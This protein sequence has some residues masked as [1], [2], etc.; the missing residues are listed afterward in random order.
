M[1]IIHRKHVSAVKLSSSSIINIRIRNSCVFDHWNTDTE[2]TILTDNGTRCYCHRVSSE[3]R[4]VAIVG[5]SARPDAKVAEPVS[6]SRASD[7]SRGGL[8]VP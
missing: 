7:Q 4:D 3:R 1:F 6:V 2:H 8:P 5:P